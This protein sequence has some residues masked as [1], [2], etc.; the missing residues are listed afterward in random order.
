MAVKNRIENGAYSASPLHKGHSGR[1]MVYDRENLK[2]AIKK[3]PNHLMQASR[4]LAATL[5]IS[6]TPI[7][8][9]LHNDGMIRKFKAFL[10]P[11]LKEENKLMRYYYAVSHLS[12]DE[13]DN[14]QLVY[15]RSYDE[16][17]LDEKWFFLFPQSCTYYLADDEDD[18]IIITRHKSHIPK[19]MFL[20]AVARPRFNREGNCTF[21]GKIGIYPF[22]E[23]VQAK[24]NSENRPRGFWKWKP[25]NVDY[26]VY[27]DFVLNKVVPDIKDKWPRDDCAVS[28][29]ALQHDNAPVHFGENE[30]RFLAA[31]SEDPRFAFYLNEQPANFPDTNI[32]D[33]GFFSSLQSFQWTLEVLPSV[34]G[35]L[36]TMDRAFLEYPPPSLDYSSNSPR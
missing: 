12:K 27:L 14:N 19:V 26:E 25:V 21:D 23:T 15:S 31:T 8:S 13:N 9:M 30:S 22:V 5:G 34:E 29:I 7:R 1:K 28:T 24:S 20:C 36:D 17:H 35:L 33:L 32:L 18:P 6:R 11:S 16:V 10:K 4:R 3:L 2:E